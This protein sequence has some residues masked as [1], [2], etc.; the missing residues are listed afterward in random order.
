MGIEKQASD[1][2]AS[3]K[4]AAG[5]IAATS[6]PVLMHFRDI[7]QVGQ[8]VLVAKGFSSRPHV[9]V[10]DNHELNLG[11]KNIL[12]SVNRLWSHGD[13]VLAKFT[14]CDGPPDDPACQAWMRIKGGH[15][16]GVS[17]GYQNLEFVDICAGQKK[18]VNGRTYEASKQIMLRVV[19]KWRIHEL[20]LCPVAADE[21]ALINHIEVPST[22]G[23]SYFASD[24]DKGYFA[25]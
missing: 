12:G 21:H 23:R 4:R 7:Q 2:S 20:S 1:S 14:V 11:V 9:P 8:E 5:C 19:T 13:N 16:R 18:V 3:E 15:L 25:K 17:V 24:K 6:H 22:G 10:L